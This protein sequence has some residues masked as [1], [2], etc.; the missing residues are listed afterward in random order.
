[1][2]CNN[3]TQCLGNDVLVFFRHE[4]DPGVFAG[5]YI[6]EGARSPLSIRLIESTLRFVFSARLAWVIPALLRS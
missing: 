4:F 2:T 1:M 5:Y 3:C 6:P